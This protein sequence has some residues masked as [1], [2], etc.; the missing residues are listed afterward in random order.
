[1]REKERE[2]KWW[3]NGSSH[4]SVKKLGGGMGRGLCACV[5]A[6]VCVRACAYVTE[7]VFVR[8]VLCMCDSCSVCVC[9]LCLLIN[10]R[11]HEDYTSQ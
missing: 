1:M 11:L 4:Y 6:C 9:V 7:S 3:P 10:N 8:D 2:T 5:C